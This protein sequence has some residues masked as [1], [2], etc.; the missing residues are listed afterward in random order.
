M[1][2]PQVLQFFS[3]LYRPPRDFYLEIMY[4]IYYDED[5]DLTVSSEGNDPPNRGF[6]EESALQAGLQIHYKE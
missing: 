4:G 6:S 1:K 2:F 5:A 3:S